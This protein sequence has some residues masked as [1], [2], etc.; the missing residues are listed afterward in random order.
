MIDTSARM[1][2]ILEELKKTEEQ[3]ALMLDP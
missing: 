2:G 1:T 3:M